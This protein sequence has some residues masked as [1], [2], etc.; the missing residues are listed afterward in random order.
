MPT[1][2]PTAAGTESARIKEP[3]ERTIT[4]CVTPLY[5][6]FIG[7]AWCAQ[8]P[9]RCECCRAPPTAAGWCTKHPHETRCHIQR[10]IVPC[11][12]PLLTPA[13]NPSIATPCCA[14]PP[15]DAAERYNRR[16]AGPR[17]ALGRPPHEQIHERPAAPFTSTPLVQTRTVTPRRDPIV[18][19][20]PVNYPLCILIL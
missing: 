19:L 7:T 18:T 1:V 10:T 16:R 17:D 20:P 15:P 9:P 6:P 5:T 12:A 8:S 2:P 13:S 3:H 14:Q 11:A 4:P